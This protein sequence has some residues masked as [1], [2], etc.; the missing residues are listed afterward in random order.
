MQLSNQIH[1]THLETGKNFNF[2]DIAHPRALGF[3]QKDDGAMYWANFISPSQRMA[4]KMRFLFAKSA[5][6]IRSNFDDDQ[7]N[8]YFI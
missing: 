7:S 6:R 1:Q 2:P 5:L 3:Q 8:G 4:E